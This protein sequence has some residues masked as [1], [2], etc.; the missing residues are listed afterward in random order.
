MRTDAD[1]LRNGFKGLRVIEE[2]IR[3]NDDDERSWI[4]AVMTPEQ[5]GVFDRI[6]AVMS[7]VEGYSN[8][9]MNAVGRD[10]LKDYDAIARRFEQRQR[11]RGVG[12]QLFARLT[13]LN[14]KMEQYRLGERFVNA[15]VEQRGKT[16]ALSMWSSPEAL[17]SMAEIRSPS[18]WIT[19]VLDAPSL[20][21]A[22]D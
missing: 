17:P 9:V 13:G 12:E 5:R 10:L 6:Q 15:V 16:A 1:V 21:Q 11:Q 4:E 20:V 18:A 2:R 7:V 14:L 3:A 22:T 8:H 19:R